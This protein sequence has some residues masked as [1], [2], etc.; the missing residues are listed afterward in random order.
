MNSSAVPLW[1]RYGLLL[2]AALLIWFGNL[3]YRKLALSDEGRYAEIPREM[4]ESGDWVTPRLNGIKYFE[5]PPLQYWATAAAYQLFGER[6]WTARLWSAL[7]GL[8]GILL[9]GYA[10]RRLFGGNAGLY[11][12]LVLGSSLLYVFVGHINTLDMGLTFFMT[13]SLTGF[14]LAQRDAATPGENRLWMHVAWGAMALS[15]LSKGLIGIALPG[16]VLVIYTLIEGDFALWKKLHLATGALL[17]LAV[18][19]PWFIAASLVNPEFPR[20]F[21]LHEHFERFLTKAHGRYEPWWYFVPI[22]A[23]G[24]LPWFVTLFDALLRAWRIEDPRQIFR[25]K[26]FLLIWAVFIYTFFS[27]S[28]SKLSSYILPIFPALALLTAER[29]TRLSGNVLSWQALPVAALA[30]VAIGLAPAVEI[31][32]SSEA[33]LALYRDYAPWLMA[34]AAVLFAG[35]AISWYHFR[36]DQVK[37]AVVGLAASGLVCAQLVLT[38]HESLSPATSAYHL[39]E[40]I[41]PDLRPGV[42]FY[43][44]GVYEQT[45]PFYIQRTVTL[46]AHQ[47]EMEFGLQQEPQRW[48]PDLASFEQTWRGQPYALAIMSP[49]R[50]AQLLSAGLPMRLVARDTRRVVVK[51]LDKPS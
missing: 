30:A 39:A 37:R 23:A 25:T 33:S 16:A 28:D 48:I 46:V 26:R 32:A 47:D 3:E 17:F 13:L 11:A 4:A 42:P 21:F 5:K 8:L 45:L 7:T 44:V 29:L 12:A 2:L 18:A 22:L 49:G 20:F 43:S 51:T 9:T 31:R 1:G 34:A 38:G 36:R 14:L 10:G 15:V 19:A 27:V 24:V 6:H 35:G 40:K 50:Y 41:K